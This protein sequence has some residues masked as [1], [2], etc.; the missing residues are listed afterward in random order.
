MGNSPAAEATNSMVT[1]SPPRGTFLLTLNFLI[2]MPWTPSAG[3]DHEAHPLAL[4]DFDACRLER[5]ALRD[6]R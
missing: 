3:R 1:G 6:D 4:G 2:S 5:E